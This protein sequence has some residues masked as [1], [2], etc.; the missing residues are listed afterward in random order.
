MLISSLYHLKK[1]RALDFIS[2]GETKTIEFKRQYTKSILKTVSAFANYHDGYIII[3]VD[4][5]ANIIGIDEVPGMRLRI[6]NAINEGIVP[7]PYYEIHQETIDDKSILILKV[8]SGDNT[9]YL[10]NGKAY[11]RIDTSSVVADKYDYENLIL[12]GRNL[13]YDLLIFENDN[14]LQFE[15]LNKKLRE[16]L[17]IGVISKDIIKTLGLMK[18]NQY[19]NGAA[20]LS[21]NNPISSAG[22]SLIRY[23]GNSVLNIKDRVSLKNIS[24]I[25][26]FDKCI[27][28]Y[29]KHINTGEVIEGPYRKTS[30]E[31]PLVAY[32]EAV[33]NAIVHREYLI[34]SDVRI[35]IF[36][37]RIEIISPGGLPPGISVDEYLD[38]RI[39]I[40]RNRIITDI[41]FRLG[42][43]ERL[44][45]GIRRIREYYK[46]TNTNPQFMVSL[47]S[48]K[49]LLPK[50]PSTVEEVNESKYSFGI[51]RT[52]ELSAN[53]AKILNFLSAN[54]TIARKQC[55]NLL[56]LKKTQT[57]KILNNLVSNEILIRIGNGKETKYI[58]KNK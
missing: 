25:K 36:D 7:R 2:N 41:F 15:Y 29:N 10:F 52:N 3:G 56:G 24:I 4:D 49:V 19:T 16:K 39:S 17:G 21:D 5:M 23:K 34:E 13:S 51:E 33:A 27:D 35:E 14:N 44:A 30:E 31:I 42:I 43:I 55:E 38:G 53:E 48:V 54:K 45:T 28:F 1:V 32:R 46:G 40:P 18:E 20:L 22:I 26:Q 57:V 9:P 12:K 6:E 58:F 11:R 8:Y 50:I 37:N 47:N